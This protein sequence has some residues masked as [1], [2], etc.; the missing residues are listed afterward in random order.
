MSRGLQL[1]LLGCACSLAA[2]AQELKVACSENVDLPCTAP[3][4][5]W[6][7]YTVSWTKL[8][9]GGEEMIEVPQEDLQTYH[10]TEQKGPLEA[11]SQGPYS[12]KIRN[13]T[14]C[15]S[16]TYRCTL[17][18]PGG[19][20]N[21]SGT[22]TLRVTG[23]HKE[24]KEE[25]FQKYRA[26][27]VLLLALVVFYITLIVFTCKFARQTVFPEF[28]KPG[29]ERVFLPVVSSSKPVEL[30]TLPKTELV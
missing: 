30:V 18:G 12:L 5:P 7:P 11:P 17:E 6:V 26:E 21:Q 13:A 24:R 14:S 3:R 20:R 4:N 16:G 23:C 27:I 25:T 19:Q 22:V 10:Q 29:M 8:T 9:E 15:S 28:S 1:L 2:A